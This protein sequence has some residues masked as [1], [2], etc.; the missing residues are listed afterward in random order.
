MLLIFSISVISFQQA[1]AAPK[2]R[3]SEEIFDFGYT[4]S[5]LKA[6]HRYWLVNSGT[7][8]LNVQHVK[9]TCGCTTVPLPKAFIAAGDS[10]PLDLVFD[11]QKFSGKIHRAVRILSNEHFPG[12]TN[13]IH[14]RK[15]YFTA[16]VAE[17]DK[18]VTIKPLAAYLDTIG[19]LEVGL[20]LFNTS[21]ATYRLSI[22]S[23]PPAFLEL[24][25][26][27]MTIAPHREMIVILRAGPKTPF[28]EYT[29]SLTLRFEGPESYAITVPIYGM[30]YYQ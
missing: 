22:A 13:K 10:V 6:M 29:G 24:D 1:E 26:P 21:D 17:V 14:E 4:P 19:Q 3:M 7:D 9:P 18:A 2:I 5:G 8:T 20:T 28:G 11:T 27:A 12:D 15:I 30:G 23:P 25:F 16:M